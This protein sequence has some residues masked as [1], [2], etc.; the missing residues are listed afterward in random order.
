MRL[1]TEGTSLGVGM[2]AQKFW[3]FVLRAFVLQI[4]E[5]LAKETIWTDYSCKFNKRSRK[6]GTVFEYYVIFFIKYLT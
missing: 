4:Y 1:S 3:V 2:N 6:R 5:K